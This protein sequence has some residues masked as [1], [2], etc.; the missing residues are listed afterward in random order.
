LSGLSPDVA[1]P[2][3]WFGSID[4]VQHGVDDESF[5]RVSERSDRQVVDMTLKTHHPT[6]MA[7]IAPSVR[8]SVN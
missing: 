5:M 4:C 7:A 8:H 2:V 6:C 1:G 3:P